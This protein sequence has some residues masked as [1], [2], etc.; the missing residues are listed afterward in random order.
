MKRKRQTE[1]RQECQIMTAEDQPST[2]SQT[3][4]GMWGGGGGRGVVS[5]W[6]KGCSEEK[7]EIVFEE[8]SGFD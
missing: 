1:N 8:T 6:R 2:Q 5:D 7:R 3:G 4:K